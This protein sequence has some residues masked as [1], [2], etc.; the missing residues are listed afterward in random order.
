M[1]LSFKYFLIIL[2]KSSLSGWKT[3]ITN[4][5]DNLDKRSGILLF[6]NLGGVFEVIRTN[7]S[8][9]DRIILIKFSIFSSYPLCTKY[10]ISSIIQFL[11]LISSISISFI[12]NSSNFILSNK[13]ALDFFFQ[14]LLINVFPHFS[15]P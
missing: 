2:A 13:F 6:R 5:L 12:T 15:G 11:F 7:E 3:S 8:L 14:R 9:T 1:N 10:S 4:E